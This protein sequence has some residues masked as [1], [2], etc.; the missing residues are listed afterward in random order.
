MARSSSW[1]E[2]WSSRHLVMRLARAQLRNRYSASLL[3]ALWAVIQPAMVMVVFWFVFVHGLK[4]ASPPGE[5]PFVALLLVGLAA[6]FFFSDVVTGGLNAVTSNSHLVRKVAFPLEILPLT[7]LMAALLVHVALL[8]VLTLGL[9]VA[10][11]WAGWRMLYLPFFVG[12]LMVFSGGLAYWLAAF[13]VF[14]RDVAQSAELLLQIWFWMTPIVWAYSAFSPE[15][16]S[17]L[18]WNPMAF[19]VEGYRYCMLRSV[20]EPP[21]LAAG[22]RFWAIAAALVVSGVYVYR[23][24]Q[25]EF[26]DIL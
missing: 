15:V 26:A 20:A 1:S 24:L 16:A 5:A 14:S 23:K 22:I 13:N 3:G 17:Y 4:I 25:P 6:W 10:G 21:D 18:A 12:S 8:T 2:V 19:I 9:I 7:P 11:E